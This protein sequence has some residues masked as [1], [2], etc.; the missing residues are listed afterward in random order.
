MLK[1][2]LILLVF[3]PVASLKLNA[4][5]AFSVRAGLQ[6]LNE[7]RLE[8][9]ESE[10]QKASFATPD[11]PVVKYNLGQVNYRKRQYDQAG[12]YFAEAAAKA[13][14]EDLKFRAFHNLG[15][16]AFRA[17]NFALAVDAYKQGLEIKE[18]EKTRYNLEQAEKKL[19]EQQKNKQDSRQGEDQQK[20]SGDQQ[21]GDQQN[22]S[23]GKQQS[24]EKGDEQQG[25]KD[26]QSGQKGEQGDENQQQ[27]EQQKAGDSKEGSQQQEGQEQRQDVEMAQAEKQKDQPEAS[28]RAKALKNRKL[29]PYMVEKILKELQERERQAQLYYRNDPQPRRREQLDP[30]N[31]NAQQLNE[32][33]R[34]RGRPQ[35][36]KKDEPDW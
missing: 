30:F 24:G 1:K 17:N 5:P 32:F 4:H 6:Y 15:N 35:Q 36:E 22:D 16:A 33:F 34:N 18:N 13:K 31:M 28:Q 7:G 23:Q 9:A 14:N 12:R 29:N 25:Q 2:M 10:F 26:R 21:Q 11:N 20:E 8:E 19:K 27:T 3:I